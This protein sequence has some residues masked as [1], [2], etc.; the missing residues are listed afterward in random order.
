MILKTLSFVLTFFVLTGFTFND[1]RT[2]SKREK[3]LDKALHNIW[4]N[5][6][7]VV[8]LSLSMQSHEK[9]KFEAILMNNDT[10]GIVYSGRVY[11][12]RA[13]GCSMPQKED[14]YAN[15]PAE[16]FDLFL[17]V[18][19]EKHVKRIDV[20]NYNATHGQEVTAKSWLKQFINYQGGGLRYGKDID[21]L[22]GATISAENLTYEVVRILD[23][24][25][26][27]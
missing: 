4:D 8:P 20:Y 18:D 1:E 16:Y 12:C 21:A 22:S 25:K 5:P 14:L 27:I 23:F 19:M 6:T 26:T 9:N 2:E 17:I 24:L 15:V 7:R 13:G 3:R 11:S 10:V